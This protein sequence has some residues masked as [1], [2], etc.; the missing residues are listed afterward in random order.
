MERW[1]PLPPTRP[2]LPLRPV[3]AALWLR[4]PDGRPPPL[5]TNS[6]GEII[7]ATQEV[8]A[9]A[10][11]T[12]GALIESEPHYFGGSSNVHTEAIDYDEIRKTFSTPDGAK[13]FIAST[14]IDTFAVAI[15]N[16]HGLYPVPKKLDL[17][18]LAKIRSNV[19]CYLSLHGGSG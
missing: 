16:L 18:L 9:Y 11:Q 4:R 1:Q 17:E 14:G 13:E 6:E 15:G 3:D 19:S 8:V 5:A 12:T 7:A 10:K 2:Q